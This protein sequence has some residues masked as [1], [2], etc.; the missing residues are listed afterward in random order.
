MLPKPA[1]ASQV[2]APRSRPAGR[3]WTS[4]TGPTTSRPVSITH[5]SVDHEPISGLARD[6]VSIV[7]AQA[8]AAPRPPST[9]IIA[10][11]RARSHRETAGSPWAPFP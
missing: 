4:A 6:A 10:A 5:A 9:A 7:A 3:P 2:I 11:S 1:I 8:T